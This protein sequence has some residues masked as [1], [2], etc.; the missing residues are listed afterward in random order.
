M[1]SCTRTNRMSEISRLVSSFTSR[2]SASV[3]VSPNFVLPPGIP[4]RF[5]HLC[6]RN[7]NTSPSRL[8]INAPT[9]TTGLPDMFSELSTN[10]PLSCHSDRPCESALLTE[11]AWQSLC[12]RSLS[13]G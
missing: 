11:S 12:A 1:Q 7:I 10:R 8:K 2:R 5:D 3:D 6:V 9:V 4:Q 13:D